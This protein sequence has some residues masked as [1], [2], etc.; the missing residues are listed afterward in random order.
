VDDRL[1]VS[2]RQRKYHIHK[3]AWFGHVRRLALSGSIERPHMPR[4]ARIGFRHDRVVP[5]T[6]LAA[7]VASRL[8]NAGLT[9]SEVG[10]SMGVLPS[11]YRHL[12]RS[13]VVGSGAEEFAG[14]AHALFSW[15]AHLRA[16][17]RVAASSATAE[18]GTVVL[19]GLV[20]GVI[21]IDAPCRVICAVNEPHRR[22]FAY[23]TLPGHPERGEEAFI[24]E[25]CRDGTVM[26]T[27]TAFSAPATLLA[28]VAGPAGQAVQ[29]R[30]TSR[31]LHALAG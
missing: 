22:G 23:G 28:K 4:W 8:R 26:F 10:Q 21:R 2:G 6:A 13:A 18:P 24:I 11:G 25:Q 1:R 19:L 5:L 14:A 7:G 16:G 29:R 30:I 9:Y 17:L 20:A 15:Q 12:R 31:Y 27:I 3:S